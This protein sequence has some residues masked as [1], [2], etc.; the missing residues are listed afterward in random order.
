MK[1]RAPKDAKGLPFTIKAAR[2]SGTSGSGEALFNRA[3]GRIE[4]STLTMKLVGK[5]TIVV[6]NMETEIALVQDQT[7]RTRTFDYNPV[8]PRPA[9]RPVRD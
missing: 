3:K 5:L 9:S 8:L 1:Y 7:L 4:S 6:S 2:L